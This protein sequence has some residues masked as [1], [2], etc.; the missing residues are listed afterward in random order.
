MTQAFREAV[1]EL[2]LD[3]ALPVR[4]WAEGLVIEL[5]VIRS[6]LGGTTV[7]PWA[8]L[9]RPEETEGL[10]R[11]GRLLASARVLTSGRASGRA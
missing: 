7:S 9:N 8:L 11:L 4:V 2:K 5:R 1:R 10:E 6:M 3:P